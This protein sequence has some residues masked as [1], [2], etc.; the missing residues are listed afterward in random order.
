MWGAVVEAHHGHHSLQVGLHWL[1]EVG[2]KGLLP[3][4]LQLEW[5]A[6]GSRLPCNH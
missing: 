2:P 6:T 5:P 3:P 4:R 1:H